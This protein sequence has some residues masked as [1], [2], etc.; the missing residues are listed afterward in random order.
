MTKC[1]ITCMEPGCN[2][3]IY[4]ETTEHSVV[5]LYCHVHRTKYGR[6]AQVR[7]V[8]EITGGSERHS[9]PL[10]PEPIV[11]LRC[12]ICKVRREV[13]QTNWIHRPNPACL[14]GKAYMIYHKDKEESEDFP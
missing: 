3:R 13:L 7:L 4:Y 10:K 5:H 9:T 8:G 11:V 2:E 6:H 12:P 14:C 1:C